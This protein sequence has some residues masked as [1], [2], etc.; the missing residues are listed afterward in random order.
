MYHRE[1][2]RVWHGGHSTT[3][4]WHGGHSTTR[5]CTSL[6]TPGVPLLYHPGYT[7]L[8]PRGDWSAPRVHRADSAGRRGPGLNPE[9]NSKEERNLCE[10]SPFLLQLE[11][12]SVQ[13]YSALPGTKM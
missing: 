8:L 3:R 6:Y 2:H 10:E 9:N 5:V 13:S 7:T 1:E 11:D 12:N 4:V